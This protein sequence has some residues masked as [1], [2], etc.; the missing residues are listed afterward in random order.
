MCIILCKDYLSGDVSEPYSYDSGGN[1]DLDYSENVL[2]DIKV[3]QK[4]RLFETCLYLELVGFNTLYFHALDEVDFFLTS[5]GLPDVQ[6]QVLLFLL[7]CKVTDR[8]S[9]PGF[10]VVCVLSPKTI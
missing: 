6:S 5:R 1:S 10:I 7:Q 8:V 2:G 3:P 9:V 4:S